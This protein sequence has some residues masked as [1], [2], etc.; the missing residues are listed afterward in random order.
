MLILLLVAANFAVVQIAQSRIGDRLSCRFGDAADVDVTVAG[1]WNGVGVLTGDLGT[2][3]VDVKDA[4]AGTAT[5][6]VTAQVD[7]VDV[8]DKA[9]S[10]TGGKLTATVSFANLSRMISA[11]GGKEVEVKGYGG[12]LM[13]SSGGADV[14]GLASQI[15]L[16]S[17][18]AVG[19]HL[20]RI[21]PTAVVFGE[22][23]IPIEQA[24]TLIAQRNPQNAEA[25]KDREVP[26][27]QLPESVQLTA[28]TVGADGLT[29]QASL[30]PLTVSDGTAGKQGCN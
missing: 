11:S 8:Q 28:A 15:A 9:L 17:Q 21:T 5:A 25:L 26:L 23:Q 19:P 18:V 16:L 2:V 4:K 27:T 7:G 29:V 6:D 13:I 3:E 20:L 22:R 14:T 24:R 10:S 30:A 12:Q 1:G